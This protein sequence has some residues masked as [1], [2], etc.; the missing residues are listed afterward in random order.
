MLYILILDKCPESKCSGRNNDK[1]KSE[2]PSIMFIPY[3][4]MW[5]MVLWVSTRVCDFNTQK[6]S[7]IPSQRGARENIT[8]NTNYFQN[9]HKNRKKNLTYNCKN[10]VNMKTF[11]QT[12]TYPKVMKKAILKNLNF[13]LSIDPKSCCSHLTFRFVKQFNSS[14]I[15]DFSIYLFSLNLIYWNLTNI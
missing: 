6:E 11:I 10:K 2:N 12:S 8:S 13:Q 1:F 3:S 4:T 15:N 5:Y 14:G 9:N 7:F